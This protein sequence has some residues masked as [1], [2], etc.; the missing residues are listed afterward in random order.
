M[1]NIRAYILWGILT[2]CSTGELGAIVRQPIPQR[3]TPTDGWTAGTSLLLPARE[4]MSVAAS[5]GD[6]TAGRML[7]VMTDATTHATETSAN[8]Q[9]ASVNVTK[10]E[11]VDSTER[12]MEAVTVDEMGNVRKDSTRRTHRLSSTS[13]HI[14]LDEPSLFAGLYPA[15]APGEGFPQCPVWPGRFVVGRFLIDV[16]ARFGGDVSS[17]FAVDG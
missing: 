5:S 11:A 14:P 2:L 10:D 3:D 17:R 9:E 13:R 6:S 1:R 4:E 15:A 8:V 16:G 7:A 12:A